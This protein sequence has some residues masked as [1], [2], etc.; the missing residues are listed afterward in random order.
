MPVYQT[1]FDIEASPERVWAVLSALDRYDEWN[2][3]MKNTRGPLEPGAQIA[4]RLV[5]PGRPAMNLKATL[6]E[7]EPNAMLSWRGHLVAPWF[8]E[9]LRRFAI[10]PT[11]G[12]RA[13]VT[14]VEDVHGFFAPVFG[15]LMGSAG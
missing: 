1:T 5:L 12:G 14:H 7:V 6:E 10:R 2:P 13:S 11:E 8:F 15:V 9:G 3:Q 4:F